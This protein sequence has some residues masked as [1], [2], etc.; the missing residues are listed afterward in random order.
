MKTF[1]NIIKNKYYLFSILLFYTILISFFIQE[2]LLPNFFPE[3]VSN[4]GLLKNTDSIRY[5]EWSVLLS[6]KI[7]T[8]GWQEWELLPYGERHFI[9]GL[10]SIF[11]A[12]I[13]P[14]AWVMIPINAFAHVLAVFIL[15]KIALFFTDKYYI[16]L[17]SVTPY[18]FFP[19]ASFWYSQL[20]KDGYYNLGVIMFCYGWMY[21]A[22]SEKPSS[23]SLN[24][25]VGPFCILLGYLLMGLI[26][27]FSLS[28][29]MV[30]SLMIFIILVIMLFFSINEKKLNWH[31]YFKRIFLAL[32]CV[33]MIGQIQ[34]YLIKNNY[35]YKKNDDG[36]IQEQLDLVR[37]QPIDKTFRDPDWLQTIID[38]KTSS[39]AKIRD[40][41]I[42][43]NEKKSTTSAIDLDIN[44][45][46]SAE[47][48][49]YIP[50]ALQISFF[51][52]FPNMWFEKGVTKSRTMMRKVSMFEML[53][54]YI[55]YLFFPLIFK[56]WLN[57][58]ELWIALFYS[59][60]V[61][62]LYAIAVPNIGTIYRFRYA[63]L[64]ILITIL[65]VSGYRFI[66][67][68]YFIENEKYNL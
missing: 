21:I 37:I 65:I 64:M 11:Y 2:I 24:I 63:Y 13:T 14:E 52:P 16:A 41:Y 30:E 61:M 42:E 5:H 32:F 49:L 25:L 67:K 35:T 36:T 20:L 6:N 12:L 19:S 34:D 43:A 8:L 44:F 50:R 45:K 3:G 39:I 38:K 15:I 46:N 60:S 68:K 22:H 62:T 33:L 59:S 40:G 29:M 51:S 1:S 17:L 26:R 7:N 10:T 48:F 47:I 23:K 66:Y 54:A 9:V 55:S 56:Y 27:T 53:L 58:A 18:M 31:Q 57:R 4:Q 28:I